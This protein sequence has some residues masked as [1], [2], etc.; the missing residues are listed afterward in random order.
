MT[1]ILNIISDTNIGGAGRVLINYLQ[2]KEENEFE[3]HVALPA[4]SALIPLLEDAG[5]VV[6]P[7]D[8]LSDQS[9]HPQDIAPLCKVIKDV[10][11]ALVHTHGALS[12]RIAAKKCHVPIVFTRHSAFPVPAKLRLP[13]GR[14]L[15]K[16]VNESLANHIIAVSPAAAQNLIDSGISENKI[17]VIMNGISPLTPA[18]Q[19]ETDALK[20]SLALSKDDFVL[21]ILA[22]IEVYKG[23]ETIIQAAQILKSRGMKNIKILIAGTGDYAPVIEQ[24]IAETNTQDI[25]SFLGFRRDVA[26]IVSVLNCQLNASFGTEATSIALLEGMS[27]GLCTIASDYGGNPWVIEQGK[28]GLIFPAQNAA[29]LADCIQ[30]LANDP[31][32]QA[33]MSHQ[34]KE[35]FHQKFT[36]EQFAIETEKIYRKVLE[37]TFK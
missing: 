33:Q 3:I 37:G 9:I 26:A 5:A 15:N 17:S 8:G 28:N 6:H 2:C 10:S 34:A 13:P 31:A 7:V 32:M 25:I 36:G 21:G 29:A 4:Q 30:T 1:R 11:P 24:K 16:L 22:R 18:L 35:I 12:G 23:H 27:L 14:W 20:A 19:A